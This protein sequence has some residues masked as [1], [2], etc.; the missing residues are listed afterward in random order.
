LNE[1]PGEN[2]KGDFKGK[3]GELELLCVGRG[4]TK[5]ELKE[6]PLRERK[7]EHGSV[8]QELAEALLVPLFLGGERWGRNPVSS[9]INKEP[10]LNT[11]LFYF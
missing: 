6:C 10:S 2:P 3:D 1:S 9:A 8:L 7:A 4:N 11:R 5:G